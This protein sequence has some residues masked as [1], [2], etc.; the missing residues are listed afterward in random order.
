[1]IL[2]RFHTTN[3]LRLKEFADDNFRCDENEGS[4]P[5]G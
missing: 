2:T 5:K 3:R 4:S 1:M